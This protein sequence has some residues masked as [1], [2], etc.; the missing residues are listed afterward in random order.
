MAAITLNGELQFPA[1]LSS[2][3]PDLDGTVDHDAIERS[4][5]K[6]AIE[7]SGRFPGTLPSPPVISVLSGTITG[8]VLHSF[9]DDWYNRIHIRPSIINVGNLVSNQFFT[10]E[11]WNA[12]FVE[13][14]LE[15]ITESGTGGLV[16]VGPTPPAIW[17][18][19]Q[20]RNY[21]ITVTT[22]GAPEIN[23]QFFF[24]W[25]GTDDDS[26]ITVTGSRIV[27][28]MYPFEAPA[29]EELEWMN[30]LI[31]SNN[32]TEQRIRLRKKPRQTMRVR[33]PLQYDEMARAQNRAYGWLT[34]RWAVPLWSEAQYVGALASGATTITVPTN[35]SD[36][37]NDSLVFIYESNQRNTSINIASVGSGVLNLSLP[38]PE[39]YSNAW[40]MPVRIGRVLGALRRQLN[41]YNGALL[42][43]YQFSDNIDLGLGTTPTQFLGQDIYFDEILVGESLLE[44]QILARV[45]EVD[46]GT[47]PVQSYSPWTYTH[48]RRPFRYLIQGLDNIWTFRKWLHR[49]A[50]RLRPFWIPTFEND[51]RLAQTGLITTSLTVNSDDYKLF[52][53]DRSHIAVS[54]KNGTWATKTITGITDIGNGLTT[55][56]VDTPFGG[57]DASTVLMIC[58]LGLKRLDT[59]RVE[60]EWNTNRVLNVVLPVMEISP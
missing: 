13:K 4:V 45:D 30:Q 7:N 15:A 35:N 46:Y 40:V 25:E 21:Q 57:V 27:S 12:Y 33:Y 18:A 49:R 31:Q 41:G 37:R 3:S 58:F 9:A 5:T 50:G 22:D 52:S 34:R 42:A 19:L 36:Y 24:D 14:E 6:T 11:V 2:V 54:F 60:L 38:V 53:S 16:F 29:V 1:E 8:A 43:D 10:I 56:G 44:D 47:G 17:E 51:L 23:A 26:E 39:A 28:L 59:D 55:L 32:G 48:L 20:S